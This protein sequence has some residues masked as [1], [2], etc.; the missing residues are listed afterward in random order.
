[1][2]LF[3]VLGPGKGFWVCVGVFEEG[4]DGIFEL[5]QGLE[6][7]AFEPLVGE[8]GEEAFDRVQPGRGY[9]GEAEDER[10]SR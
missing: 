5:L 3:G 2:N 9:R 1:M 8:F 6:H 7:S 10:A 4:V